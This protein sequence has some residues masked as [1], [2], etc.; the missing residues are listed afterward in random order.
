MS[1]I[2]LPTRLQVTTGSRAA[3]SLLAHCYYH[4]D[5]FEAAAATFVLPLD[6]LLCARL[7]CLL[8]RSHV[9]LHSPTPALLSCPAMALPRYEALT[10][11]CPGVPE[12]RLHWAQ[13][14]CKAGRYAEAARAAAGVLGH[15]QA[16]RQL[17]AA[18]QC[19]AG[20]LR[21]CRAALD[22]LAA[23]GGDDTA[24]AAAAAAGAGCVLYKEGR[25][26]EAAAQ[27]VAA[28]QAVRGPARVAMA[29]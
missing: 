2:R 6:R 18:I 24:A 28:A 5:D 11:R 15:E 23:G 26:A 20:D 12:Y 22:A 27:F 7:A 29:A 16:V 1:L 19:E 10:Q 4:L 25:W 13:A 9:F 8:A 3:L 21:G 17:Q 14:L